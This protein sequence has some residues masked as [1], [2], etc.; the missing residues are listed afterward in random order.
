MDFRMSMS[1]CRE[2]KGSSSVA[3]N[4]A[5]QFTSAYTK[6]SEG[7]LWTRIGVRRMNR[8]RKPRSR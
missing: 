7:S 2:E 1:L 5:P 4:G 8:G 3:A 6:L